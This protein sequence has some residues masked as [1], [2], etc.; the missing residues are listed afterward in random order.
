MA[1]C[2]YC[3]KSVH[4]GNKVS[5]S[6]RRANKVWKSNIKRVK[7]NIDGTPKTIYVCTSCLRTQNKL[8][9]ANA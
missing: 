8:Q 6:H 7:A 5:H 2:Y 1:K 9:N 4:F 3:D